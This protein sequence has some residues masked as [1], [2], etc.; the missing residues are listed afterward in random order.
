[1]TIQHN[2][3]INNIVTGKTKRVGT[4]PLFYISGE[5]IMSIAEKVKALI[6]PMITE[7][8]LVDVEYKKEVLTGFSGF[9]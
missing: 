6:K 8:E 5:K 3:S 7:V 9:I 1:M 2:Y 4:N